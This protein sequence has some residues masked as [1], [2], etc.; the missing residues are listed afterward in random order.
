MGRYSRA[1]EHLHLD[2]KHEPSEDEL[3][4]A[5]ESTSLKVA[6]EA[7][8]LHYGDPPNIDCCAAGATMNSIPIRVLQFWMR[9]HLGWERIPKLEADLWP[10]WMD[11]ERRAL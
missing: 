5:M 8:T 4:A 7:H 10:D 6:V 3:K 2:G 11:E 9:E 1:V